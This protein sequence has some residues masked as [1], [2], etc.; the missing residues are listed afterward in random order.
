M[1]TTTV[2][3]S[4]LSTKS[5]ALIEL[6]AVCNRCESKSPRGLPP[7]TS[8]GKMFFCTLY[9]Y[10][11]LS[12]VSHSPN[13]YFQFPQQ[14]QALFGHRFLP[15]Q[16]NW[17]VDSKRCRRFRSSREYSVH[18]C[19]L[20]RFHDLSNLTPADVLSCRREQNLQH[21]KE[22]HNTGNKPHIL[23]VNSNT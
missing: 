23:Y 17:I 20:I 16:P 2:R 10:R 11:F 21:R 8:P 3:E 14:G 6:F 1:K 13:R 4:K 18:F 7:N 15:T 12:G 22:V 5:H 19:C 9:F